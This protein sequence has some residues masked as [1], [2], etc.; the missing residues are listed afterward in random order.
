M[1]SLTRQ[2]S[3]ILNG[4]ALPQATFDRELAQ[5]V[6]HIKSQQ[7][8]MASPPGPKGKVTIAAR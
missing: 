6:K 4:T 7:P 5:I 8:P 1:A 2:G 3:T